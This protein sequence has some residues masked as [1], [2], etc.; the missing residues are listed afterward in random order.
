MSNRFYSPKGNLEVW[1]EKP[2]GYYTEEEW[3]E[4]HPTPVPV[5]T[6]EEQVAALDAQYE[7][8]KQEILNYY[9]EA[10]FAGDTDMQND[11][12]AEMQE[13]EAEYIKKREEL[14][15]AE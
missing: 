1:K 10:M 8:D 3:Q 6:K 13:I 9:T 7:A 11:L 2:K 15:G 4:L 14:E 12:K 5:P